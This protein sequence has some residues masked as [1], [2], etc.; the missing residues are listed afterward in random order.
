MNLV[1]SSGWLEYF[2]KSNN[3]IHFIGAIENTAELIVSPINYYE[4]YRKV[5]A[6]YGYEEANRAIGF[7]KNARIV[8][9]NPAIALNAA[10]LSKNYHLHMAEGLLLATAFYENAVL[11]TMDAHFKEIPGVKYFEKE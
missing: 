1:D 6:E 4:I 5:L 11:W 2:I 10:V 8:E 3:A 9:I 7:L